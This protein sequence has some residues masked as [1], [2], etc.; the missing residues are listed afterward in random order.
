[1]K[2]LIKVISILKDDKG[3][4][5][6]EFNAAMVFI[7]LIFNMALFFQTAA[8]QKLA[9]NMAARESAR[10]YRYS[11]GDMSKAISVGQNELSIGGIDAEITIDDGEAIAKKEY[12]FGL[13]IIGAVNIP[14][15]G[16]YSFKHELTAREYG[17]KWERR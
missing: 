13:P 2:R 14:L 17:Q 10:I 15:E 1:M 9:L 4:A 5:I 16:R 3:T 6:V 12:R 8:Y 7:I 11:A